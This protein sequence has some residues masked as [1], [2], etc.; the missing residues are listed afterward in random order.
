MLPF[1]TV[2]PVAQL[3]AP[4]PAP[5]PS[6]ALIRLEE[7]G[8][9]SGSLQILEELDPKQ[10]ILS[11]E[12]RPLP[13]KLDTVPV[14]NSNSPEVVQ[15]EGILLS[16]FPPEGM[17]TPEAHLNFTFNG[18]FDIFAHHIA[19]ARSIE[20]TRTLIQGILVTNPGES[21]VVLDILQ[22]AS[23]LTRPD[24]I[25]I[26]L[27][28]YVEDPIGRVFSG[29]GSR[30]VNDILRGRRLGNW[31][32]QI[33]I[34]PGESYL[35]MNLPIPVGSVVP[36]SNGRSTLMRLQSNGPV[37]VANLA[38]F[39]P[40]DEA[41][42]ERLPT[43]DEWKLLLVNGQL[44]GPRDLAPSPPQMAGLNILYGR[45]A[46]VAEG[47]E[48]KAQITDK[49]GVDYLKIPSPGKAF[50]YGISLLPR[51]T[52][53]TN[54][55]QSAKMLARYRDTA[56][57]AHGNYGVQY[58]L[59]LPLY[60]STNQSQTVTIALQTPVKEDRL[61]GGVR[62][63]DPPESRIFYR[64]TVRIQYTDDQGTSQ[65]RFIHLVQQRGQQGQPL[66]TLTLPSGDR[67]L[68]QVDL[69]Y[70]PDATPPQLLTI[71]TLR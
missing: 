63:L 25:F 57:M 17:Q 2:F 33:E 52:L 21:P 26:D 40:Q 36:S 59:S 68:V 39:A 30:V 3:I 12:V 8:R 56:Y 13:G 22:A 67:R 28:A 7:P 38:M 51:G 60:N 70:P 43:L 32:P 16:T 66:A 19:R 64:G 34:P 69:L 48:W 53:G 65:T 23:Y 71:Q 45:V 27:P 10:I 15:T 14:F 54:Q 5:A 31:P 50:S 4:P 9:P 1:L 35:L 6:P 47:S 58:S 41:G 20:E 55:V 46:G 24:A 42:Q 18:R 29:P 11:Q 49:P 44:A 62:F 61:K 37:Y